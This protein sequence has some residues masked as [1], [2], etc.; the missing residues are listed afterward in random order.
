M[1]TEKLTRDAIPLL[2]RR[3]G[4]L[5]R[6]DIHLAQPVLTRCPTTN[7]V[8]STHAIMSRRAL[9]KLKSNLCYYCSLCE[10]PHVAVPSAVWI[11]AGDT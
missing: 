1:S 9:S 8:T 4:S 7:E 10:S 11:A 6:A 3:H 2:R 5:N